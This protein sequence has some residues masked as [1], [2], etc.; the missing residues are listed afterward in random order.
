MDIQTKDG[1][2]LRGIPDGTPDSVIKE[3]LAQIRGQA[4]P[5]DTPAAP[6]TPQ[7]LQASVPMRVAQGMRDPIDAGAQVL[8]HAAPDWLTNALDYLPAKLRNSDSPLLATIGDRFFADPRAKPTDARLLETERQYEAARNAGG[9][10]PGL[11]VARFTGNLFSPVNAA[12]AAKLPAAALNTAPRMAASGGALGALGG[13]LT[14]VSDP[15]GQKDFV[16]AKAVQTGVGAATGAVLTPAIGKVMEAA[17]P[18]ISRAIT[19]LAGTSEV[20][21]ARASLETDNIIAKALAEVGQKVDDLPQKQLMALRQQV[22][23]SLKQGK[24]LDAAALM[25]KQDFDALGLPFTQGQITRDPMQFARERNLRGVAGVGEPLMQTFDL[26]NQKLQQGIGKLAEGASERTTAGEK[27]SGALKGVDASLKGRVSSMYTDARNSAG[28]DLEVPLKGLAQ[29]A[30]KVI[31]D[32]AD[33]VPSAVRQKLESYGIL[34]VGN[35]TKMFTF[36]EANKLLQ[37]INDHVGSDAA[38][39]KALGRLRDSVKDA[40]LK[41]GSDDVFAPA[42]MAASE[43]FRLQDAIPALKAASEGDVAP[44]AFVRRFIVNGNAAEVKGLAKV[45]QQASPEAYK[46]ARAQLGAQIQRA[47]FGENLTGDKVI[48]PERLAKVLRDLG[49]EKLSA[50]YTKEEIAMMHRMARVGAYANSIPGVAAINHSNTA[51]TALNLAGMIPGVP[52][53]LSVLRA[54]SS[55]ILNQRAVANAV[56]GQV[57]QALAQPAPELVGALNRLAGFG[58]VLGSTAAIPR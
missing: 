37:T 18:Y 39:N 22:V 44:D 14:P 20:N 13:A 51:A 42:R 40:M 49:T 4:A 28:K 43:R 35:Q 5:T 50:F 57:P 41:S 45:L 52:S 38:T 29:D 48:A 16:E 31:D 24:V 26:Q 3:R 33:K 7:K 56:S 47:A 15:E 55:P 58:G 9:K 32:F 23:E 1:I 19:K 10:D 53:A 17:A 54:V 2:I 36:D 27:I 30:A 25:R 11:D 21:G 12:L 34:K 6:T 46:E 8:A